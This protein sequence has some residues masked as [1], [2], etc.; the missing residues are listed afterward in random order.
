MTF[1]SGNSN[2]VKVALI[3]ARSGSKRV[4]DKNIKK[5]NG[6]PLICYAIQEAI[7]S[8]QFQHVVC[9]TDS[10]KYQQIA[11]DAGAEVPALRPDDISR[12]TSPDIEWVEWILKVLSNQ[13]INIDIICILRP[14][15]PFRT[16]ETI[17]R[18]MDSFLA[19]QGQDSLRAIQKVSEH[20]GK[21]WLTHGDRILPLMPFSIDGTPW[22]SNQMAKL[23]EIY[24]QNASL[25]IAWVKTVLKTRTIA[26]Q[27]VMPFFTQGLEGFDINSP[28]D[29][30]LAEHYIKGTLI[31]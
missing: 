20:P 19:E 29:W 30:I 17:T 28:E 12:D 25:E 14:T 27:S 9:V 11:K 18:A 7:K 31:S 10:K 13:S 2:L 6:K 21:M 1:E 5:L 23:P 4:P 8:G 3:P 16:A 24:V 22:H 15:S 26:G